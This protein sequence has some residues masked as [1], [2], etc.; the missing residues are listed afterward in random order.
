[1]IFCRASA[2]SPPKSVILSLS[3]RASTVHSSSRY[4][5]DGSYSGPPVV[6]V[7]GPLVEGSRGAESFSG[8]FIDMATDG[9]SSG[10]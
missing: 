7:L 1:M 10:S 8:D 3:R 5:I 6:E 4:T 9:G 2:T